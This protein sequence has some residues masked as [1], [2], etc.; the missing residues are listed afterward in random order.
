MTRFLV[1]LALIPMVAMPASAGG[2]C[3]SYGSYGC[4]SGSA[5]YYPDSYS[6]C[7]GYQYYPSGYYCASPGYAAGYYYGGYYKSHYCA[8]TV[9]VAAFVPFLAYQPVA[10]ATYQPVAAPAATPLAATAP[11]ADPCAVRMAAVEKRLIALEAENA[12]LRSSPRAEA[13]SAQ[14]AEAPRGGLVQH[15][16]RC[17][18]A[19]VAKEKGGDRIYFKDGALLEL[20]D[21]E[22]LG[23]YRQVLAGKMP[24]GDKLSDEAGQAIL[25][26][27][28]TIKA[29]R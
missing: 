4:S 13:P 5:C 15:C 29:K 14:R 17:H 23:M 11:V 20:S 28:E 19:A 9:N 26:Q 8:P 16:A 12:H 3:N 10:F 22:V 7:P 21:T 24:K 27:L 2:Y 18:D 1:V 6:C 25:A